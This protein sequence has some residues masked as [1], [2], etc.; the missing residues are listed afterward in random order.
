MKVKTISSSKIFNPFTQQISNLEPEY[1]G[2]M[3]QYFQNDIDQYGKVEIT[4][5]GYVADYRDAADLARGLYYVLEEADYAQLQ[6][7]CQHKVAHSY[8]QQSVAR[9]YIELYNK[10]L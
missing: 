3:P 10:V 9:R 2:I 1:N 7:N 6:L 5:N 8:S 4:E